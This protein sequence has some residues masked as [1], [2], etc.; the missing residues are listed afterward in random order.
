MAPPL[1]RFIQSQDNLGKSVKFNYK[2]GKYYGT[3]VGGC[4]SIMTRVFIL[5]IAIAEI[6]QCLRHPVDFEYNV[7]S[8]LNAPNDVSY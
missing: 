7:H 8:Q 2:R 5:F 4:F 3:T 6:W 1:I